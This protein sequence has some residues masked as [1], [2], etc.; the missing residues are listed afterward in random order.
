MRLVAGPCSFI[1]APY[2]TAIATCS[3]SWAPDTGYDSIF[4]EPI[5][6]PLARFLDSLACTD[7]LPK[8]IFYHLNPS[9][10]LPLATLMTTFQDGKIPGKMQLGSGW[11]HVDTIDGMRQQIEVLSSVGSLQP[12]RW[13]AD[14]L[15]Q[16]P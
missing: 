8:C 4:D 11:W 10:F 5:I 13:H 16:L 3:K 7:E 9:Q 14:R 15:P 1:W 12:I 2:A 6:R